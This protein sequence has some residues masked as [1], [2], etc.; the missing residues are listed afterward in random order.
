[1]TS[2]AFTV[3]DTL[4]IGLTP[5][6]ASGTDWTCSIV[7]QVVN[8]T[9]TKPVNAGSGAPVITITVD[10]E[11]SA[12]S[13]LTNTATISGGGEIN[14]GN[15]SANDPTTITSSADLSV[16]KTANNASPAVGDLVTFTITLT[17]AGPSVANNVKVS[18][19]LPASLEFVSSTAS[20][21]SYDAISGEWNV[22]SVSPGTHALTVT[23]KVLQP[24]SISNSAEVTASSTPD[25]DS[26]PNDGKDDDFS[27][28][29]LSGRIPDLTITKTH[30]GNFIRGSSG[31]YSIIVKNTGDASTQG[32][33][34]VG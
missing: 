26:T 27:S 32:T 18:D 16:L 5:V 2:T 21:G 25:P 22:G 24:G 33:V 19:A 9:Y 11:Q 4:P 13:S 17:N 30:T 10:V 15:N 23:V 14:T 3:F 31:T 8:C 12:G 29:T 7:G 34:N 20:L 1:V 6:S 28:V